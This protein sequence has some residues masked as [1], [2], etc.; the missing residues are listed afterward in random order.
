LPNDRCEIGGSGG[1]FGSTSGQR[2]RKL[3]EV[4]VFAAFN[5]RIAQNAPGAFIRHTT[6]RSAACPRQ[7]GSVA[8]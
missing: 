6:Y 4:G 1:C 2:P 7:F 3:R 5:V 8:L